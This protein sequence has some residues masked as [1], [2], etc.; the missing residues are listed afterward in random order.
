MPCL[1]PGMVFFQPRI[2]TESNSKSKSILDSCLNQYRN[3][4]QYF[5]QAWFNIKTKVRNRYLKFNTDTLVETNQFHL[6]L[7][8]M[9]AYRHIKRGLV[10]MRALSWCPLISGALKLDSILSLFKC[11]KDNS[12]N[13]Q[14][15]K[16]LTRQW[17]VLSGTDNKWPHES[18]VVSK[19]FLKWCSLVNR[20]SW[21]FQ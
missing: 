21:D 11:A 4:H 16:Y 20:D 10:A 5:N 2:K 8:Y 13:L 1:V 9:L 19:C 7:I 12:W 15:F 17:L 6:S 3:Q 18:Y 14:N